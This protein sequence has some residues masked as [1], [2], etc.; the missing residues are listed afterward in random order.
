MY[1]IRHR[2]ARGLLVNMLLVMSLLVVGLNFMILEL[3]TGHT[4]TRLQHD[5]DSL[6]SDLRRDAEGAWAIDATHVSTIYN[7]VRSGHYYLVQGSGF[8]LRSRSLFDFEV[9]PRAVAE[10]GGSSYRMPGPGDEEWL[11]YQQ[12][13]TKGGA[14]FTVWVAEDMSPIFGDMRHFFLVGLGVVLVATLFALYR[15]HRIVGA[16]FGVFEQLRNELNGH[17]YGDGLGRQQP[18]PREVAPL[19]DEINELL[20]SLRQRTQRTRNAIANLTHELKRPL[21]ILSLKCGGDGADAEGQRA[22]DDIQAVIDR[23]LKRARLS[24]SDRIGGVF[25]LTE[26]WPHLVDMTARIY[27]GIEVDTRWH[28]PVTSLSFDRGDM[29]ELLGNLLD[30]ACKFA[31]SRVRVEFSRKSSVLLIVFEDDGCGVDGSHLAELGRPGFR[32]DESVH[33]HGLGLSLCADIVD[34][35]QGDLR[36]DRAGL[37]GLR[38][39]VELPVYRGET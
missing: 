9:E 5:A 37:G 27:P 13:V 20:R 29:L 22:I 36:F 30:N 17:D 14:H 28:D 2:L 23:E 16:S 25:D 24:G 19:V 21:Q 26:E 34:S 31:R 7:R 15:Q 1:S 12:R 33:G 39:R 3:I 35:F 4:A 11:V 10:A 38:V 8:E 6:I 32:L 18:V